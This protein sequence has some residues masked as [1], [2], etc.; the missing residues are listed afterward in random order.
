M[1]PPEAPQVTPRV[2]AISWARRA[3]TGG[4]GSSAVRVLASSKAPINGT[5]TTWALIEGRSSTRGRQIRVQ[6]LSVLS[7]ERFQPGGDGRGRRCFTGLLGCVGGGV[8]VHA[9][10]IAVDDNAESGH[11]LGGEQ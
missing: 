8:G 11:S 2:S 5:R 1:T 4:V 3:N 9:G 6:T 10:G 7:W